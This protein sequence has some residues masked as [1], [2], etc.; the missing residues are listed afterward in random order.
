M[1]KLNI[2]LG[3]VLATQGG[4][5]AILVIDDSNIARKTL[6]KNLEYYGFEIFEAASGI[7]GLQSYLANK[8]DIAI[9]ILDIVLPDVPGEK[10]LA[11][12]QEL[13]PDVKVVVC[14]ESASTEFKQQGHKVA[15]VLIKPI[16]MDR[17]LKVLHL[18]LVGG[19]DTANGG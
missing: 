14:T 5:H 19:S 2:D 18:T 12:L 1:G 13:D 15:G 11:K 7:E 3:K 8:R 16:S 10:V 4:Q 17:L 6:A 9:V